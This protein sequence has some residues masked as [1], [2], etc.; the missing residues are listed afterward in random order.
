MG[1]L[2]FLVLV[3]TLIVLC[4]QSSTSNTP[5]NNSAPPQHQMP[6]TPLDVFNPNNP[7]DIY[8]VTRALAQLQASVGPDSSFYV[9]L[10]P[11]EP[12][13]ISISVTLDDFC[14][15]RN[16][17]Y[18]S[19]LNLGLSDNDAHYLASVPFKINGDNL[20]YTFNDLTFNPLTCTDSVLEAM[21][22][23]ASKGR[24]IIYGHRHFNIERIGNGIF[25][26]RII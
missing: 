1:F 9:V 18:S 22:A 14:Q 5:K 2:F 23:G 13:L 15:H 17:D 7:Y 19:Y 3:F 8:K 4:D 6:S 11:E 26:L 25:Q 21:R 24:S 10:Q 20:K 16:F 12:R